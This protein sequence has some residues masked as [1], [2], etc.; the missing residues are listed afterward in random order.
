MI[1]K[2]WGSKRAVRLYD[3]LKEPVLTERSTILKETNNVYAFRINPDACK[4][5]V[6]DAIEK[7]YDVQVEKVRTVNVRGKVKRLARFIS[8]RS[9]WKKAFVTLKK[10]QT[11]NI[12]EG[13]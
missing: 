7:F 12:I 9:N 4:T 2:D 1:R 8:K 6:K 5:Q 3:V 11:L 13:L 10:G